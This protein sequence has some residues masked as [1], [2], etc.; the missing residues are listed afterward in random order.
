M[1][2][3]LQGLLTQLKQLRIEEDELLRRIEQTSCPGPTSTPS[4][5]VFRVGDHVWITN[6][7]NRP[8]GWKIWDSETIRLSKLATVTSVRGDRVYFRTDSGIDTWRSAGNLIHNV[9]R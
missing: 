2:N 8:P 4:S 7:I 1:S 5:P 6:K 3:D 9:R